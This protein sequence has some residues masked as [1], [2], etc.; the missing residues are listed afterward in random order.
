[1]PLSDAQRRLRRSKQS[2]RDLGHWLMK[3]DGPDPRM[4]GI[5]TSTGRVGHIT[6][7]QVDVLS[8]TYAA[9]NKQVKLPAKWLQWWLQINDVAVVHGK[10]ALLR[11]EPS[12]LPLGSRKTIPEMHIITADRHAQLLEAE[13]RLEDLMQ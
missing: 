13:A 7:M 3:H 11:I 8:E 1:M 5:A 12:N 4:R 9:E 2:E 6:N 10:D